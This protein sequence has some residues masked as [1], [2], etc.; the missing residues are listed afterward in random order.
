MIT[1]ESPLA[2]PLEIADGQTWHNRGR[3]VGRQ[4]NVVAHDLPNHR[5]PV[6]PAASSPL[7]KPNRDLQGPTRRCDVQCPLQAIRPELPCNHAR[8]TVS[9]SETQIRIAYISSL[10]R[11]VKCRRAGGCVIERWT[12][13]A[14]LI[15]VGIWIVELTRSYPQKL[16]EIKMAI[17]IES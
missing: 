4:S 16:E 3:L 12:E 7:R 13:V 14:R 17:R 10:E 6:E 15:V 5:G 1:F 11:V 9:K 8:F 2:S